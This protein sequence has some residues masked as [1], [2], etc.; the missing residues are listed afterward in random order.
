MGICAVHGFVNAVPNLQRGHG[1][2][3]AASKIPSKTP[4]LEMNRVRLPVI[5]ATH[6]IGQSDHFGLG[7]HLLVVSVRVSFDPTI[8]DQLCRAIF[9]RDQAPKPCVQVVGQHDA[10]F[11]GT[12]LDMLATNRAWSRRCTKT[13]SK[14]CLPRQSRAAWGMR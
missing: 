3:P 12:H 2:E 9:P 11:G 1:P 4:V 13:V 7:A 5:L 10:Q 14:V 6:R 8:L